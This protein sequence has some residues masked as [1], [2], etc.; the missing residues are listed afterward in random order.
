MAHGSHP[1]GRSP[2]ADPTLPSVVPA[3][4]PR[5][6]GRWGRA[7]V[8]AGV[9][10]A[11]AVPATDALAADGPGHGKDQRAAAA[12][13]A[14]DKKR[15]ADRKREAER[16]RAAERKRPPAPSAAPTSSPAPTGSDS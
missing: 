2:Q 6:L 12:K 1:T 16:R 9:V 15:E 4:S 5:R 7:L 11:L 10:T 13:K 8:V 3:A 14:A